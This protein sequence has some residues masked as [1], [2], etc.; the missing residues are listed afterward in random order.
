MT[1]KVLSVITRLHTTEGPALDLLSRTLL[2]LAGATWQPIQPVIVTQ[3]FSQEQV[4]AIQHLV[5]RFVWDGHCQPLILN[6][7]HS[8][9][10]DHRSA[11]L[12]LGIKAAE[13]RY[14]AFLDYDDYVYEHAYETLIGQLRKS[15]SA[16]AFGL[17]V[18]AYAIPTVHG[19]KLTHKDRPWANQT[20]DDFLF[21]N[22]FPPS[23]FVIDRARLPNGVPLIDE[24]LT[25]LEDYY[26][27]LSIRSISTFDMTCFDKPLTE[28]VIRRDGTTT[29]QLGIEFDTAENINAWQT[30]REIIKP[31]LQKLQVLRGKPHQTLT[32]LPAAGMRGT[33]PPQ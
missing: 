16:I 20:L 12:N 24:R 3:R 23:S 8:S 19:Y 25:R 33:Q 22:I 32:T 15:Q 13:G 28:Y 31:V 11:L 4:A 10:G 14:L 6:F 2:S 7:S 27:L 9:P 1:D 18:A 30:S 5:D 17:C 21:D 26:L 29:Y